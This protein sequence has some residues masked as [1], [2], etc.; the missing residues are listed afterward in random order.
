[1]E[2]VIKPAGTG[3]PTGAVVVK[4]ADEENALAEPLAVL[5]EQMVC[6]C[7][8]YWV[9]DESPERTL[10]ETVLDAE[11]QARLPAGR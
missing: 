10:D 7:H 1:M 5:E 8:S 6:T 3:Q 4:N 9:P 2:L 11:I